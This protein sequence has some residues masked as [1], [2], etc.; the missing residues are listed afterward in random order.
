MINLVWNS[1]EG[2]NPI[3]DIFF[4]ANKHTGDSPIDMSDAAE[5]KKIL[6]ALISDL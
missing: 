2:Q 4:N 5:Q 1:M 6:T 3:L